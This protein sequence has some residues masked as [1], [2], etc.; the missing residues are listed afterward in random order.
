MVKGGSFRRTPQLANS[1]G[2]DP[3]YWL[4]RVDAIDR[5]ID[6]ARKKLGPKVAPAKKPGKGVLREA[7]IR[8]RWQRLPGRRHN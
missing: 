1:R 5:A 4:P 6:D 2:I 3:E 7:G 8:D